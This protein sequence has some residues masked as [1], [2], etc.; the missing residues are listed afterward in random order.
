MA[1][2]DIASVRALLAQYS[3]GDV[4]AVSKLIAPEFFTYVPGGDEPT[5]TELYVGFAAEL[6]AAAPDLTIDIPDLAAGEDGLLHGTAR[7][8]GTLTGTLWGIPPSGEQHVFEIPLIVRP[9]EGRYAFNLALDT[10]GVIA[11]L[12][13]IG[14]VNVADEMHLPP[15]NPVVISDFILKLAFTG[16]V[17]DKPCAHLADVRVIHPIGD[18]CDDCAPGEIW[19][20][21]RL[22]LICGHLGCC[23]TSTNKHARGHW[24]ATGHALM[25]SIRMDEGWIWCYPDSA[26]FQKRTLDAIEA[27]LVASGSLPSGGA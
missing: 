25:R 1:D 19:P 4:E 9:I 17:A 16:Q 7:V 3:S 5:A 22:C 10:P 2:D 18:V 20:T 26:L 6:K 23:D 21:V 12:R 14:F 24:E 11:I 8:A 15:R 13:S 27:R